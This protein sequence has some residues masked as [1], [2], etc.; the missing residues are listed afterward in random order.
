MK[1]GKLLLNKEE[2]IVF[3]NAMVLDGTREMVPYCADVYVKDGKIARI[4]R[5]SEA[6]EKVGAKE[7]E[8][9]GAVT[10]IKTIEERHKRDQQEKWAVV[11]L[12]GGYLMPGLINLHVH[13]NS[14]GV[15]SARKKKPG[16]YEKL[17]RIVNSTPM[18][19]EMMRRR[20]LGY[21]RTALESGV[22]TIRTVGGI[23]SLDT[24]LRGRIEIGICKGPRILAA[25]MGISVPGGHVAGS[26]A[27]PALSPEH[28]RKLVPVIGKDRPDLIKLMVTGGIMD[29]RKKG[30]PGVLKMSPEIIEAAC[31]EAHRE[32]FYVAAHVES[33]EGVRAALKGGVDCIE[34]G[35][36]PDGEILALFHEKDAKLVTTIS[37]IIPMSLCHPDVI[38]MDHVAQ[39]NAK[40]VLRGIV[41]NARACLKESIPVGL[42]TD[43]G[44]PFVTHYDFWREM[45]YFHNLCGVS[46]RETLYTATLGNAKIAGI[47][48]FTGSIEV[49]KEADFLITSENPLD[50]LEALR[51]PL[52]V[53]ARGEIIPRTHREKYSF[54]EE[55]LDEFL[56][57]TYDQM[58]EYGI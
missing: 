5:E 34:H 3:R 27:Y 42:G 46:E 20:S 51:T 47:D 14:S 54:I 55:Q 52:M 37:P 58:E 12:G 38:H 39:Y 45:Q 8:S 29:A 53:V 28:A 11:D 4:V 44:C 35:A 16:D 17:V 31:E 30:E 15:P 43:T 26:L 25:N 10:E 1:A 22:T 49:G 6:G 9:S 21:A 7:I 40:L 2:K 48:K 24:D 23:G 57:F 13:L 50:S 19:R 36:A 41:E 33:T 56:P 18:T 32:G